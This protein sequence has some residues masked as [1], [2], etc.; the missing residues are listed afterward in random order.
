MEVIPGEALTVPVRLH[1]G[2]GPNEPC[3]GTNASKGCQIPAFWALKGWFWLRPRG[4]GSGQGVNQKVAVP[5][6]TKPQV[7]LPPLGGEPLGGQLENCQGLPGLKTTQRHGNP[8]LGGRFGRNAHQ[9]NLFVRV[10]MVNMVNMEPTNAVWEPKHYFRGVRMSVCV[11]FCTP[12]THHCLEILQKTA[13]VKEAEEG[14]REL[15]RTQALSL[16]SPVRWL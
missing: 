16:A 12:K 10:N 4:A 11:R 15:K 2:C 6:N 1:C 14:L 8:D 7:S 13:P 5:T 3:V 9:T